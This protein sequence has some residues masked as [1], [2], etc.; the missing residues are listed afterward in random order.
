MKNLLCNLCG[1]PRHTVLVT[2]LRDGTTRF[3]VHRCTTCGHVQLLPK[4]TP[5]EDA[6]YYNKNLQ[7]RARRKK[8][9]YR[10]LRDNNAFDTR[11]HV[12]Q[13]NTLKIRRNARVLDIGA[14]YGFFVDALHAAGYS[15]VEGV[16]IS[17]ERRAIARRHTAVPIHNIDVND[18]RHDAGIFD[19]ITVFHVLEHMTDP[20]GFLKNIKRMLATGGRLI[21]EV[22]NADELLLETSPA[23][24][25]FYW[26]RAHLN[27]F[28]RGTLSRCFRG[29][30]FK[31]VKIQY[32]Q[33]YG[34]NNLC[35]WLNYG[36]PQIEKPVFEITEPY[37]A[38]EKTYKKELERNGRSDALIALGT[39]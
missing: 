21:V 39:S 8:I 13:F 1:S 12:V 36:Q 24:N 34:L 10:T 29:A 35:N 11:R 25:A 31:S 17:D 3:K 38:L 30:G 37:R 26:I 32:Q 22:P 20:V 33:R 6:A 19:V 5:A 16:E 23:Y 2:Q 4:P 28:T 14:G 15:R 18:A 9:E 27:Y 7:D